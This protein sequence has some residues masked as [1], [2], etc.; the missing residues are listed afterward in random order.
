MNNGY[1]YNNEN[2]RSK[3]S[4]DRINNNGNYCPENCRWAD[5]I[6]QANNK[7]T[8][9]I[10]NYN[11]KTLSLK[12]WSKILRIDYHLLL[13]RLRNGWSVNRAFTE[14]PFIGKNQNWRKNE[15]V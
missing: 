3:I 14:L 6:T 7:R 2:K 1:T 12:E 9:I 4:L 11:G 8:N 13:V 5:N 10:I 15:R